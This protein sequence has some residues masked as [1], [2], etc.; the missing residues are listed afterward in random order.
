MAFTGSPKDST[1]ITNHE[2]SNRDNVQENYPQ[3]LKM[4]VSPIYTHASGEGAGTGEINLIKLPPGRLTIH[5]DLCRIITSQFATNAD[6]HIGHR[7]YTDLDGAT[8]SED[9]DE[10]GANLDAGGGALDAAFTL[11]AAPTLYES[12]DGIEVYALV[13]T[14]NIEVGDTIQVVFAFSSAT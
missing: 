9:D 2:A 10:W 7:A 8:V 6:L 11:P 13:D 4:L 5:P 12:Q 3:T 1:W 14:G